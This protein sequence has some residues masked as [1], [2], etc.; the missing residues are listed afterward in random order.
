MEELKKKVEEEKEKQKLAILN[1]NPRQFYIGNS[2]GHGVIPNYLPNNSNVPF[3]ANMMGGGYGIP[4]TMVPTPGYNPIP[5][6]G[7]NPIPNPNPNPNPALGYNPNPVNPAEEYHVTL[8]PGYS[9][10]PVEVS[11]VNP[12]PGHN[13]NLQENDFLDLIG[14]GSQEFGGG[15]F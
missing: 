15:F 10:N 4:N 9:A 11:N 7:Y 5:A 14:F 6:Q 12:A 13:A 8:E 1:A 3:G 2:S